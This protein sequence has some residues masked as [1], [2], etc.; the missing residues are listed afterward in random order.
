MQ[1]VL[2]LPLQQQLLHNLHNSM[3]NII[4]RDLVCIQKLTEAKLVCHM[5]S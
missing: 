3:Y 1:P 5:T 4:R 2:K